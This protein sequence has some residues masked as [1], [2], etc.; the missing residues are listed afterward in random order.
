MPIYEYEATG[1]RH[2]D[3]CAHRFEVFQKMADAPLQTCPACGA[4]VARIISAHAVGGSKSSFD[5]RAKAAGFSKLQ[6]VS[7]GEYEKKY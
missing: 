6:K 5:D 4:P 3:H 2:C 1:A 7:K